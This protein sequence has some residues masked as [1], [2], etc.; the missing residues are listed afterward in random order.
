MIWV[1]VITFK[2]ILSVVLG[3]EVVYLY[4]YL[5]LQLPLSAL[6]LSSQKEEVRRAVRTDQKLRLISPSEKHW[7]ISLSEKT[8]GGQTIPVHYAHKMVNQ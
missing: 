5:C 1:K 7:L 2:V 6:T 4:L 8:H 3:G